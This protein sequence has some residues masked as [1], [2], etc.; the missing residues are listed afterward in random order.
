MCDELFDFMA[1]LSLLKDLAYSKSSN[2]KK[3][4]KKYSQKFL[5]I[6]IFGHK[7][8]KVYSNKM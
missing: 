3:M 1:R 5:H 7:N 8:T 6:H 2:F 4:S